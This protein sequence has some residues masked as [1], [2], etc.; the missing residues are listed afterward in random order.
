MK[1][2]L[3]IIIG[4]YGSGKSEFAIHSARFLNSQGKSIVLA[5]LDVVNPYFRSRDVKEEFTAHGIDVIAP[6]GEFKYADLPMISPRIKGA[7][8]NPDQTV[9]ID[10]GGD[11]A[12][13][14]A[15]GRFVEVIE[16]RGYRML[17][18]VNTRRPFTST[19]EEII[20][21]RDSLEFASHLRITELVCNTNLMEYTDAKVVREGIGIVQRVSEISGLPFDH[22]LALESFEGVVTDN[23]AGKGRLLM[24]Y[25][26]RKPWECMIAKGI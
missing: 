3:I 8:Q 26:L 23:I 22:Y 6:E 16:K 20:T 14:R 24:T 10:V 11:P 25:T 17:F 18:V 7:I 21:M 13:C 1:N 2:E 19:V 12:G 9:I 4:A 15:L 5:D